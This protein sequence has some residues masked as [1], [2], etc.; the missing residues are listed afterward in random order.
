MSNKD[1]TH[2]SLIHGTE[3]SQPGYGLPYPKMAS[4]RPSPGP[5]ALASSPS[6]PGSMKRRTPAMVAKITEPHRKG[7]EG[8]ALT[9]IRGAHR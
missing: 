8:Y 3:E 7:G 6:P 4:H 9:T 1:N 5:S 2:Q